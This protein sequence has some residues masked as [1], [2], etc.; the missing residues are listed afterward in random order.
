MLNNTCRGWTTRLSRYARLALPG[1]IYDHTVHVLESLRVRARPVNLLDITSPASL[2]RLNSEVRILTI[3][4]HPVHASRLIAGIFELPVMPMLEDPDS[5]TS[6]RG[7]DGRRGLELM[8]AAFWRRNWLNKMKRPTKGRFEAQ[9]RHSA[10]GQR[11]QRLS[12]PGSGA[13]RQEV[14]LGSCSGTSPA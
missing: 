1:D 6:G 13:E 4:D 3:T 9:R 12:P 14:R 5:S 7:A 11:Q 8:A 2:N 10:R